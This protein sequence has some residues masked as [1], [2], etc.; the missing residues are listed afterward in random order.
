[1]LTMNVSKVAKTTH[2]FIEPVLAYHMRCESCFEAH[3]DW[4]RVGF[5]GANAFVKHAVDFMS[6]FRKKVLNTPLTNKG[7]AKRVCGVRM[8]EHIVDKP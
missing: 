4:N 7:C 1:M 3:Q 2:L 5:R 8:L 6:E